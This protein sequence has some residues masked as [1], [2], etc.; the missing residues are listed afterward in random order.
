MLVLIDGE[1]FSNP[2]F[3]LQPGALLLIYSSSM[4]HTLPFFFF[5]QRISKD[6]WAVLPRPWE[7]IS[8]TEKESLLW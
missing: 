7:F 5:F 4:R 1:D 3:S 6:S 2:S 8:K